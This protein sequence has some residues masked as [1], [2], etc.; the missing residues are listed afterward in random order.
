MVENSAHP[1]TVDAYIAGFPPEVQAILQKLRLLIKETAPQAEEKIS[2]SMPGYFLNGVLVW[3]GAWKRHIAVYP[4]TQAML[5]IPGVSSFKGTKGSVH[6]PLD[7]PIPYE[8]IRTIVQ[9]RL[10]ENRG[11]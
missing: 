2:Y 6:F 11:E 9:V 1:A 3:F 4:R 7:Q 5:A 10:A 8:L